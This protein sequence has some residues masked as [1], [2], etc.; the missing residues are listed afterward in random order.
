MKSMTRRGLL[1]RASLIPLLPACLSWLKAARAG[2]VQTHTLLHRTR[3]SDPSWPSATS[4]ERLNQAVG[5]K[6][7]K[8]QSPFAVCEASPDSPSCKDVLEGLK[9]PYY[10]GDEVALTQTS[11]WL[12]AWTSSPSAYA[13]A[14][15]K[16]EDVVAAV[17]FARENRLRLVVKGGG[18]SYQGT[19]NAPDSLLVWTRAMNE[20]A[21]HDAFVGT[22]CAGKQRSRPAV[23]IGAGA[24][25]MHVYDAVTTKA[26]R[27][28]QGGGCATVGVAGLVQSGGFGSFS[29]NYG[30]AASGLLEAEVV[31]A[32]GA[33]RIANACTNPDLFWGLKGGGGGSLGIVTRLT[34]ATRELPN[35]F[36][37]VSATIKARSDPAYRRLIAQ[38]IRF[39]NGSLFNRHWGEQASFDPSNTLKLLMVFQ[40][41]SQQEATDVWRPFFDWIGA[42][43][44]DFALASPP[45]IVAIPAQRF[46]DPSTLTKLPGF[47]IAD[48]RP[49]APAGNVFWAGN[50]GEA[51][52]F[53]HAYH[54]GWLP[55]SLLRPDQQWRL[56]DALFA[57][58]RHWKMSLHFNKGL[59]GAPVGDVD[60]ARDTATNPAVLSAFALAI[61][62][63]EGPPAFAGMPGHQPDLELARSDAASIDGAMRE[64]VPLV[65]QRGSYV[66]ESDFFDRD[67]Q[68]SYWGANYPRLRAVKRKYDPDGLFFVHHGV[69][70]EEWSAD[71]FTRLPSKRGS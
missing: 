29:K 26:G 24:I 66:S 30:L 52:Q 67:W 43:R 47:V 63:G 11:G 46:W 25:W 10:I 49:G 69:G 71:G 38:F 51:G 31:T 18:H 55:D 16:T 6:L 2:V 64:M 37:V 36:G 8:V 42:S 57:S 44:E 39:Y 54:S 27:Y 68:R 40:G 7:I 33:V 23:S 62:A 50:L 48:A 20:I 35:F 58:S 41:L 28:V 17:N 21:L 32:D 53:L 45:T 59:A 13:V 19:S 61:T 65:A 3:P 4:W 60:A 1:K 34:L 56:R 14:A 9:N 22:G 5:G 12:D 70:S 15:R